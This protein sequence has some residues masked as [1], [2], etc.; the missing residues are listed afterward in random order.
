MFS[1]ALNCFR[2]LIERANEMR[3]ANRLD[4][5]ERE[6]ARGAV[7]QIIAPANVNRNALINQRHQNAN[8][9]IPPGND[10]DALEALHNLVLPPQ[11]QEAREEEERLL[12]GEEDGENGEEDGENGEED[13]ENGEEV[14]PAQQPVDHA[15]PV[16]HGRA[17][18]RPYHEIARENAEA[19]NV[20]LTRELPQL[21]N[22]L[23]YTMEQMNQLI[24][25]QLDN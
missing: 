4:P 11:R 17:G 9:E 7:Q 19:L 23:Q 16:P 12:L 5:F 24:Q 13:G 3:Y 6:A 21:T 14:P 20:L 1:P 10:G 15:I 2:G 8:G 25:R 22:Q 18:R